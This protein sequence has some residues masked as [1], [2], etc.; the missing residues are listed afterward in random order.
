MLVLTSLPFSDDPN[1]PGS[2]MT[3]MLNLVQGHKANDLAERAWL[4]RLKAEAAVYY[5]HSPYSE[6]RAVTTPGDDP[7]IPSETLRAYFLGIIFMGGSSA[8]NA[9]FNPRQP[10]INLG[11]NVLQVLVVPCGMLLAKILPDWGF[12]VLRQTMLP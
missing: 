10:T 6:V 4:F 11:A 1:I 2:T 7:N 12:T 5:F 9:F 8:I 3:R